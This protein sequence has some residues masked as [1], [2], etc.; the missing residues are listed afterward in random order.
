MKRKISWQEARL[1]ALD[2]MK[3]H[4]VRWAESLAQETWYFDVMLSQD[5]VKTCK[6]TR[7]TS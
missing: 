7:E 6:K 1:I 4:D 5:T 3:K 2:A